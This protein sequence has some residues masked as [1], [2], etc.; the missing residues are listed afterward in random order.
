[1]LIVPN[2]LSCDYKTKSLPYQ[3]SSIDF[4]DSSQ[5][6]KG[7]IQSVCLEVFFPFI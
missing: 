7:L 1:M 2:T 3:Y 4:L 5:N 6:K